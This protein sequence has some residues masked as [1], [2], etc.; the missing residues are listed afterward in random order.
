MLLH[1][2]SQHIYTSALS[3]PTRHCRMMGTWYLNLGIVF[4]TL[5]LLLPAAAPAAAA[6]APGASFLLLLPLVCPLPKPPPPVGPVRLRSFHVDLLSL[7]GLLPIYLPFIS[8]KALAKSLPSSRLTMPKPL[9][10]LV[11]LSRII[12]AFANDGYLWN[13][14]DSTSSFTSLPRSPTN[15]RKSLSG[16]SCSV[17]SIQRFP[18]AS[19]NIALVFA[20][21][22]P[23][24][25]DALSACFCCNNS[26]FKRFKVS[27]SAGALG[28]EVSPALRPAR[29][30]FELD[31][32]VLD[33][34][35][36]GGRRLL[37]VVGQPL[38]A[39]AAGG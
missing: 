28:F 24:P 38:P 6:A 13:A 17:G 11:R 1:C 21:S 35:P 18:A 30:G 26:S 29:F 14:F 19:L 15:I 4:C 5:F 37:L 22:P 20:L 3:T 36:P 32:T 7:H 34:R 23:P 12:F 25:P 31:P 39:A 9:L 10:L 33:P 8:F 2:L 27:G 16:H